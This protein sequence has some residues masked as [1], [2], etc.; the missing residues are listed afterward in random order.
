MNSGDVLG[1]K[2]S[3]IITT[4]S[5]YVVEAL[6]NSIYAKR[7]LDKGKN[8]SMLLQKNKLVS[9]EDV[10]AYKLHEGVIESI[11]DDEIKQIDIDYLDSCSE[12]IRELY[13]KLED[14]EYSNE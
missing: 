11:K 12:S 10:S 3:L 4:H 6:N 7:L 9:Y 8:V 14:I 2:N 1:G 13:S 5:P